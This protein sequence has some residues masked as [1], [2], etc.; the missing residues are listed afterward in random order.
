MQICQLYIVILFITI[1]I[2]KQKSLKIKWIFLPFL[3]FFL[4]F[5]LNAQFTTLIFLT[6]FCTL[7][8]IY[9]SNYG[10]HNKVKIIC[11]VIAVSFF[12]PI[13]LHIV[14]SLYEGTTIGEKLI[15]FNNSIFGDG[16][17]SE[18]SGERSKSQIATFMLFL[19]SPIWGSDIVYN[20]YNSLIYGAAHST[21]LSVACATGI[22]G[23]LSYYKTYWT[24]IKSI[25]KSYSDIGKQ[26]IA[27]VVYFFLF[28]FFNPSESTEAC[29]IIFMIV[30]LLYHTINK[31]I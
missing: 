14:S 9:F 5:I 10:Q 7:L 19:E 17:I 25:F 28:S 22:I 29:W 11:F 30:P 4:Y 6:A 26:Y 31:Y 2:N 18:A 13:I 12:I 23:L 21:M 3:L 27:M 20:K 16:N 15:R 1:L 24:I 8:S